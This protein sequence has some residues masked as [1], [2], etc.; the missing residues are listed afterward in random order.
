MGLGRIAD[1]LTIGL[2]ACGIGVMSVVSLANS[3]DRESF[4]LENRSPASAPSLPTNLHELKKVPSEIDSYFGD[5]LAFRESLLRLNARAESRLGSSATESVIIGNEG[6]LFQNQARSENPSH[7]PHR[8]KE[9]FETWSAALQSR[10]DWLAA[11]GIAYLVVLTPKQSVYPEFVPVDVST[12]KVWASDLL[13]D[14]LKS[15]AIP[16]LDLLPSLKEAKARTSLYF[17]T[18]THWT[19]QGALLPIANW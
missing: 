7:G 13:R 9:Q 1:T 8:A 16:N 6:W 11:R 10:N 4:A 19:D 18:D 5:R 15:Q 14:W 17:R 12:E 3:P 2:F